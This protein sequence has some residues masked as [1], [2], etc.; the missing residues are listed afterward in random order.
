MYVTLPLFQRCQKD[1]RDAFP[2]FSLCIN[3]IHETSSSK[4]VLIFYQKR[5]HRLIIDSTNDFCT[6]LCSLRVILWSNTSKLAPVLKFFIIS[7][8]SIFFVSCHTSGHVKEIWQA[9]FAVTSLLRNWRDKTY[10]FLFPWL[11]GVK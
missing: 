6:P 5:K 9:C 8:I 1:R 11:F 4:V 10:N 2:S 7:F 3:V